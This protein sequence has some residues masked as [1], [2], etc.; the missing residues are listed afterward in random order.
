MYKTGVLNLLECQLFEAIIFYAIRFSFSY[1]KI[2]DIV[3][4]I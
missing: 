3:E 4:A 1:K 2:T